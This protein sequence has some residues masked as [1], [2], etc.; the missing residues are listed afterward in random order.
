[1]KEIYKQD[2]L[3]HLTNSNST[4][5]S[6]LK[7]TE[8]KMDESQ[9]D[10]DNN[11]EIES[12]TDDSEWK[13]QTKSTK[14][15]NKAPKIDSF[16]HGRT[17][18]SSSYGHNRKENKS[19]RH[20]QA[21]IQNDDSKNERK[22]DRCQ[23]T[24]IEN[25]DKQN[26]ENKVQFLECTSTHQRTNN[27]VLNQ[28]DKQQESDGIND[29]HITNQAL[30]FAVEDKFP[31]LKIIC[32]PSLTSKEEADNVIKEF[33]K[34]IEQNFKKTNPRF[35]YPLGFDNYIIDKTGSLIC[36]TKYIELFVYMCST[37]HYPEK[38]NNTKL[39]P[40]LP[41]RLPSRNAVILKFVDNSIKLEDIQTLVKEKMKSIFKVEEMLG[42]YTY[43]SR[44]IRID[45]LS[46]DEYRNVLNSGKFAIGGHLY[47]VDEYLPSP[48]ILIC[49]KCNSPG[50]TKRSCKSTTEL[51]KRCGVNRNDGADHKNCIVK[52][53]HCGEDHE[54]TNFKCKIIIKFR[55]NLLQKL[56]ENNHL[57][58]QHVQF[59]IP[60]KYRNEKNEK[61]LMNNH[62]ETHFIPKHTKNTF[63]NNLHDYRTWP[64]LNSNL[65]LTSNTNKNTRSL[66]HFEIK[67]MQ[68]ELN[69]INQENELEIKKW[70]AQNEEQFKQITQVCQLI[71]L[72]F[73]SQRE[74]IT[75]I[76]NMLA[77][78]LPSV[79][80]S[81]QT[82]NHLIQENSKI[83]TNDNERQQK[84][85]IHNTINE[86]LSAINKRLLL[87]TDQQTKL[88]SLMEREN[89]ALV[90]STDSIFFTYN[91]Q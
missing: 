36:F 24:H 20:T 66:W 43:R 90:R 76:N 2:K 60:Q 27:K 59:Y 22:N 10:S 47:D 64:S 68:E 30:K 75:S 73:K 42:T 62:Y 85:I 52:C 23:L 13:Y 38:I 15:G 11:M 3:M 88:K 71:N 87:L 53:H 28:V 54:A 5:K 86:T 83:I 89:E 39:T 63:S 16:I 21:H 82:L 12:Q 8:S 40:I 14:R 34:F 80:Q 18:T 57:I 81:I 29:I 84:E 7:R 72:H 17:I 50:H 91:E 6:S 4:S 48:K 69:L 56:K 35:I 55:Q 70:K 51:C 46:Q 9:H 32:N 67:Q 26:R 77:D 37:S 25:H 31:P 19:L 1:M 61:T 44:H 45:L 58:P 49:N 33:F 74:A 78:T 65:S 79:V 41:T